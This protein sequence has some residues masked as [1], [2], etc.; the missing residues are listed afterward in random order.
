[1]KS[2]VNYNGSFL[3]P[4]SIDNMVKQGGIPTLI[5]FSAYPA[6]ILVSFSK[7][8]ICVY[9]Q[10]RTRDKVLD[11]TRFNTKS[12]FGRYESSNESVL[13][14]MSYFWL[15]DWSKEDDVHIHTTKM[16]A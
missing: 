14:S 1:M 6:V 10:F 16:L 4:L 9:V 8:D 15:Y 7:T 13:Q 2:C 5:I 3:K 12:Q 11:L